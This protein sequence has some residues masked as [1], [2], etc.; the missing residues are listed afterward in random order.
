ML[1]LI[2]SESYAK[3]VAKIF[4]EEYD[5]KNVTVTPEG[6][7]YRVSLDFID[8]AAATKACKDMI[9]RKYIINYYFDKKK[10]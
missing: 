6:K 4:A 5:C 2:G 10:Q 7:Y 3:Q 8:K 1:G 9:T